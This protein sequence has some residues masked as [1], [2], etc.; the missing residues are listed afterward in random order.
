MLLVPAPH[1][2]SQGS[3][4]GFLNLGTLDILDL[5]LGAALYFIK[6]LVASLAFTHYM[7]IAPSSPVVTIQNVSDIAK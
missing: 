3:R 5:L 6:Y 2:E 1:S 7:V 4:I